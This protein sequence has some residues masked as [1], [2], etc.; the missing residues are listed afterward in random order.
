[1]D[2]KSQL[3]K[4]LSY[5]NA[6]RRRRQEV[7][8]HVLEHP[9]MFPLLLEIALEEDPP[10]GSR[11]CWVLEFVF[12]ETPELLYPYMNSFVHRLKGARPESSIRPLAKICE[13]ILMAYYH[14][15]KEK[16]SAPLTSLHKE[17]M[18]AACFDWLISSEKVAP[19][20]YS[21]QSLY[22]LGKDIP[23]IH[24][25]LRAL[26]EQSYASGSPAYQARARLVLKKMP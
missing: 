13:L 16:R 18:T 17:I 6:T 15:G 26:L 4:Q 21:M 12:R 22:L 8:V 3:L 9:G 10:L 2:E 7:A 19:K 1:M 5:V 24:G 14:K 11:A 23:W 25:E 20:A